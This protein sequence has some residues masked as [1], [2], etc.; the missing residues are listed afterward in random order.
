MKRKNAIRLYRFAGFA[1]L[2]LKDAESAAKEL[3]R[4]I[5]ELGFNAGFLNRTEGGAF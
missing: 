1:N 4:G 2:A 5:Q 3:E